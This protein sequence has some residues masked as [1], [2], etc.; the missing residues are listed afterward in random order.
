MTDDGRRIVARVLLRIRG[1]THA[2]IGLGK[3]GE[4]LACRELARRGYEIVARRWRSRRGEIDIIARD[5]ATLV[6]VEV[7]ARDGRAFGAPAEA[8]TPLKQR[9]LTQLATHYMAL[10]RIT[11]GLCRFDVVSIQLGSGEPV[12]EVYK[13]A[14]DALGI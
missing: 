13:N 6:F 14:F 2:R 4:N 11:T 9:R 3:S 1:M 8:V 5:G 7:K 10:N 12:I